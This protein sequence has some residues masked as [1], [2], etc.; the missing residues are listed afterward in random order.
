[1]IDVISITYVIKMSLVNQKLA[2]STEIHFQ[3]RSPLYKRAFASKKQASFT[4]TTTA[5]SIA[6][7]C[8]LP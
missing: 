7:E 4:F 8:Q 2:V 1:M 5:A 6:N 3:S